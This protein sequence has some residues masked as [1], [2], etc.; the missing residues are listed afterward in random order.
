MN[1]Y[2]FS[3]L[4]ILLITFIFLLIA[5]FTYKQLNNNELDGYYKK[6]PEHKLQK[7]LSRNVTNED[8]KFILEQSI[9]INK[10]V[11]ETQK[12]LAKDANGWRIYKDE[13][14]NVT[15][16]LPPIEGEYFDS[17]EIF[18]DDDKSYLTGNL[19]Q[20][21]R[22]VVSSSILRLYVKNPDLINQ[23]TTAYT[24]PEASSG[25]FTYVNVS[26]TNVENLDVAINNINDIEST[27][28]NKVSDSI[29]TLNTITKWNN[30][31]LEIY[32]NEEENPKYIFVKDNQIIEVQTNPWDDREDFVAQ[33]TKEIL[34]GLN[35]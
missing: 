30:D 35:F 15:F 19:W 10:E 7:D 13:K 23:I 28:Y 33:T 11:I 4:I 8:E 22:G 12:S 29:K 21:P 32:I 25:G 6:S 5:L 20:I 24:S 14:C 3:S 27:I 34:D 18:Y 1:K 31:V 17:E 16:T 26:C 2:G 9:R